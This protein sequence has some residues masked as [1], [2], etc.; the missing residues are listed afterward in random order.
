[1]IRSMIVTHQNPHSF[2]H[3]VVERFTEAPR[4]GRSAPGRWSWK[5]T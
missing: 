4:D 2:C 5:V 1:M 3:A